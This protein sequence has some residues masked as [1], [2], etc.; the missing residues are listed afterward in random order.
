[1]KFLISA[2][3]GGTDPGNTASGLREAE[4]VLDLR[5]IVASKLRQE[6]HDVVT[7]GSPKENW[8]LSRAM[9]LIS[10]RIAIELHTN[11]STIT[12]ARGVETLSLTKDKQLAQRISKYIATTLNTIVRADRGWLTPEA[13]KRDRG[14][15]PG[16]VRQGGLIV[17]VFF[18]SNRTELATYQ[19][20]KWLVAQAIVDALLNRELS[21]V[22]IT[23][24]T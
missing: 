9:Q 2:G 10:G 7:D 18:Q 23:K 12:T 21:D 19:A 5:N 13:V 4:L 22:C 11:A 1:M 6:G 20:K 14:F 16:F 24:P 8:I 3:H 15:Y 17:E